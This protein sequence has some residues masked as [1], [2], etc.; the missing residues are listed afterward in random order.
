MRKMT[1]A[2]VISVVRHSDRHSVAT[3]YTPTHGR[4]AC[5]VPAPSAS[6]RS[7]KIMPMQYIS[8]DMRFNAAKELQRIGRVELVK[9]WPALYTDP[10]RTSTVLFLSEFLNHLLRDTQPDAGLWQFLIGSLDLLDRSVHP[11]PDFH[12]VFIASLAAFVGIMPDISHYDREKWFDLRAGVYTSQRPPH[13]DY[14]PPSLAAW[15]RMLARINYINARA[16]RLNGESRY[17]LLCRMLHYYSLHF[18]GMGNVKSH[19]V[20][21]DIYSGA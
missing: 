11:L 9:V 5:L 15:P 2:I 4:V 20:L 16:L 14:L 21:R 1:E 12:I 18:P 19:I 7:M 3:L 13:P 6:K 10:V 17:Q 8:T